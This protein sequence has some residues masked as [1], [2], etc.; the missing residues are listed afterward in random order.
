MKSNAWWTLTSESL[1][2]EF[3]TDT[4]K[5]LSSAEVEKRRSEAGYNELVEKKKESAFIKFISQFNDFI[6]WVL[7]GAAF[8]SGF[9]KE[10]VDAIAIVA[11][12]ILNSF[13]G[14]FQEF[15]A[16][17]ALAA[18]KK[19]SAPTC[20]VLRNGQIEMIP[21]RELIP[22]D[23][24]QMEAGDNVPADLRLI[25]LNLFRTQEAALTGESLPIEKTHEVI[26]K[27]EI[28]IG[29]R[30]NMCFM[31]TS[32][33]SGKG[34]GI[35]IATG[36][37]TE[38]GKI[39]EMLQ[40]AGGGETPLQQRLAKL[41]QWLV[42][43]C[44]GVVAIVFLLGL[45]RGEKAIDMFLT[46]VSL[47]VAAIP[48]GLPA[49]VTIALALGVQRMVKRHALI[50]KLPS[51]ETLGCAM[52]ICSDKTGTLTQNQMTVK[53]VYVSGQYLDVTGTGYA[54][55]GK[56]LQGSTELKQPTSELLAFLE[57]AT[58]CN[59]AR[60]KNEEKKWDVIG[61]PTEGAIL[62]ASLK[63]GIDKD[64]MD[65]QFP[66]LVEIPFDSD[67]KMMSTLHERSG[68]FISY[69]KGAPDVLIQKC[70]HILEGGKQRAITPEDLKKINETNEAWAQEALRVL[71]VAQK[72][73]AASDK[74][75]FDPK[76]AEQAL[77]F[78]GLVAM[79]DP[80]RPEVKEAIAKCKK[81]GI[82]SVMITGDHKNTAVAIAR[83]LG[84]LDGGALALSGMELDQ[85][86]DQ[87]LEQR[88]EHVSVY[89][90]VSAEHKL[91]VVKAW[92]RRGKIVAM[93]GDGVNDAPA[94]KEAD[95]G[96]AMGITGTDV[97]KEASD[98]V[99]TDDNFASIVAAVEE[100][101]GIYENIKKSIYYLLSCNTGE[102]LVMFV[103]SILGLP[104][105]LY[106]I[107]ILWVNIATDGLPA[108][109]L[110]MDPIEKGIMDKPPRS[111]DENIIN[112]AFI[113]KMMFQGALIAACVLI[114]FT[115]VL[116]VE[117]EDLDRAKGVAFT[118]LVIAQL[119]HSFNCRS[120]KSSIFQLGVFSNM[121]LV[122]ANVLSFSLQVAIIYLPFL[123]NIFKTEQLSLFDWSL[124][125]FI[126]TLPLVG[127][128]LYKLLIKG[129]PKT[130]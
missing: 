60:L 10:W 66:T 55:E 73:L 23:V 120:E 92:R 67:R 104:M 96:V 24:V 51:V 69:S 74:D 119:F 105:P 84:M 35:V 39:A 117:K 114:A 103:A 54:P 113:L 29:D 126:S 22:G 50:R 5:G 94:V 101:R 93:T 81:A 127:V 65:S 27:D 13:I 12:V 43:F 87:D 108:I 20:K 128:E 85:I 37:G 11:I 122:L 82:R 36:M 3:H 52:V 53:K 116:Y 90:R 28:G 1:S 106:P 19:M 47:A 14:F 15:R 91:R 98:M 89:A 30:K 41:G 75:H 44:M 111:Q 86:S 118:V 68:K 95:I 16:E 26:A 130:A 129:K 42:Y 102:I 8:I 59:G 64:K 123:E 21:A 97:T 62:S 115:Y 46:S 100:G 63:L 61:D 48:E 40:D 109:A 88:V 7:L 78:L 72:E 76:T 4:Q 110:G 70:T 6:V 45:L 77:T 25:Q 38:L 17:K 107:Q 112:K 32:V 125:F 49:I 124:C 57:A 9:L 31:G 2:S 33:V 80:P 121:N 83:E 79:I 34:R 58:L 18:L 71:A 99:V 56:F